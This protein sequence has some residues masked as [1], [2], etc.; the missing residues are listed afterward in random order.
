MN[1]LLA[2]HP[3]TH[4]HKH[5]C[6]SF[7]ISVFWWWWL[8]IYNLIVFTGDTRRADDMWSAAD[9]KRG[10]VGRCPAIRALRPPRALR[11]LRQSRQPAPRWGPANHP[12][13]PPAP[14]S[15]RNPQHPPHP[16]H[17]RHLRHPLAQ[18]FLLGRRGATTRTRYCEPHRWRIPVILT[19]LL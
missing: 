5:T 2:F 17:P 14:R 16:P 10:G 4:S 15:H 6:S 1:I 8:L 11:A 19:T 12:R 9:T 7:V 3:D 18:R 13:V